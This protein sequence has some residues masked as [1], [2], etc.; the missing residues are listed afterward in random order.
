MGGQPEDLDPTPER[1]RRGPV[2][3][4]LRSIEDADGRVRREYVWQGLDLM[5][6]MLERGSISERMQLAGNHFREQFRL[7]GLDALFAA[8][9]TRLPVQLSRGAQLR[10][11]V[12]GSEEARL[13]ITSA[14]DALGGPQSPPGSCAWFCLG[15]E[16]SLRRWATSTSWAKG[17]IDHRVAAGILIGGLSILQIHWS[18]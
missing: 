10:L 15:C 8:D 9:P 12:A 17:R 4:Q 14:L 16:W 6:I 3:R 18:Y 2:V 1:L 5:A 13:Q 11:G 7:A